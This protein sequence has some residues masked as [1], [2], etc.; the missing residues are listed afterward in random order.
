MKQTVTL[1]TFRWNL[2]GVNL[3]GTPEQ[4]G[5]VL[6]A[7]AARASQKRSHNWFALGVLANGFSKHFEDARRVLLLTSVLAAFAR[8]HEDRIH[9]S[10]KPAGVPCHAATVECLKLCSAQNGAFQHNC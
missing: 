8:P 4:N 1:R 6:A 3:A 10:R 9:E 2:V 7:R 5:E